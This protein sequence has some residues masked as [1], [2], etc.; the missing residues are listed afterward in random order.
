MNLQKC[1][2][3]NNYNSIFTI[4]GKMVDDEIHIIM[5]NN[6]YNIIQYIIYSPKCNNNKIL[7]ADIPFNRYLSVSLTY[8]Y[9]NSLAEL[10]ETIISMMDFAMKSSLNANLYDNNGFRLLHNVNDFDCFGYLYLDKDVLELLPDLID[11]ARL[12]SKKYKKKYIERNIS[13]YREIITKLISDDDIENYYTS[14]CRPR[15]IIYSYLYDKSY[16][17]IGDVLVDKT[18]FD[19]LIGLGS[20]SIT[21]GG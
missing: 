15:D 9:Q 7:S 21:I 1:H 17:I 20:T 8:L 4:M 19:I 11:A 13:E 18:L 12:L 10:G 6:L 16:D 5:N 14:I 3:Y 2:T